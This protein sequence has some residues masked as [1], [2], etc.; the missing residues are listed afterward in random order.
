MISSSLTPFAFFFLLLLSD[1]VSECREERGKESEITSYSHRSSSSSSFGLLRFGKK[2]DG[3]YKILQV[4]DMHYAD[5]RDTKCEDVFESQMPTCSDLN[6]TAFIYR[7]I[8]AEN[9][10]LIVFT[11]QFFFGIF[12]LFCQSDVKLG[13]N[14]KCLVVMSH[15]NYNFF[16]SVTSLR[17]LESQFILEFHSNSSQT[18]AES[19]NL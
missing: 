8:Q 18:Q 2:R 12:L 14:Q 16:L 1:S 7:V 15:W 17:K 9:P 19:L 3:E 13:K 5:G 4:A 11:G 10:D 6:T